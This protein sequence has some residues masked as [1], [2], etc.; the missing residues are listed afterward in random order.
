MTLETLLGC[1]ETW[2]TLSD[3][4]LEEYFKDALDIT[5]PDRPSAVYKETQN[6]KVSKKKP[7]SDAQMTFRN[8]DSEKQKKL[9]ELAK[10]QG[11]DL[12][13]LMK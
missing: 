13:Q 11:L 5:R 3:K 6:E 1:P 7:M 12:N 4:Q 9:H 2:E 8:M 10:A